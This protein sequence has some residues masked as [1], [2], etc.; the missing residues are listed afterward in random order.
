MNQKGLNY[1]QFKN[2]Q[3]GCEIKGKLGNQQS[4]TLQMQMS[5]TSPHFYYRS[6]WE[7]KESVNAFH[8]TRPHGIERKKIRFRLVM[9]FFICIT[10]KLQ[11][12]KD[13]T[14]SHFFFKREQDRGWIAW[15]QCMKDQIQSE[16]EHP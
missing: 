14:F 15:Q 6:D 1:N 10:S 9:P 8:S 2:G 16:P 13:S 7:I 12:T 11:S 3:N 4:N 5:R